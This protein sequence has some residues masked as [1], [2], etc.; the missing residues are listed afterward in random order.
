MFAPGAYQ[1][2]TE[3]NITNDTTVTLAVSVYLA[4]L[5]FGPLLSAPLSEIYGR[6]IM[7]HICNAIYIGFTIGCALSTNAPMFYVFRFIAGCAS[8]APV[9]I[10]GGTIAD[11]EPPERRAGAMA[12]FMMGALLGPVSELF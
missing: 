10:G 4:G 9:A 11:L 6:L 5:A 3:F 2:A 12:L 8:S 7:Y 1:F